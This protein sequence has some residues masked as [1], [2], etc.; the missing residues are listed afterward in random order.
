MFSR[1]NFG[2]LALSGAI[3]LSAVAF[4][5]LTTAPSKEG[6]DEKSVVSASRT[7]NSNATN[8]DDGDGLPNW[9]ETLWGTDP[10]NPDSDGDGVLDG[11]E[12]ALGA[13]PNKEG[14]EPATTE[15]TY[16]APRGLAPTEALARELFANYANIRSGGGISQSELDSEL[17]DIL[18][19]R[20][21]EQAEAKTYTLTALK[22]EGDVSVVAYEGSLATILNGANAVREYELNVFA[23]AVGNTNTIELLKLKTA[24]LVYEDI[25]K[26]LVVLEV[27]TDIAN[28]HLAVINDVSA[29]A[30]ATTALGDWGGD[31]LDALVL[32]NNFSSAETNVEESLGRLYTFLRALKKQV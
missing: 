21:L 22:I 1:K 31:P 32:V 4:A 28:E 23:R 24:A 15:N 26:K 5:F 20:L 2:I 29:L 18:S 11:D 17:G 3:A 14:S 9:K 30:A 19:R 6:V 8:D 16:I 7:T 25:V 27:P 10:N 12:V 13:N